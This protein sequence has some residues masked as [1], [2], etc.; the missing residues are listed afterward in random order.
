MKDEL[1]CVICGSA[2]TPEANYCSN[3]GFALRNRLAS[4]SEALLP[5]TTAYAKQNRR[6]QALSSSLFVIG[7]IGGIAVSFAQMWPC[8]DKSSSKEKNKEQGSGCCGG[9]DDPCKLANDNTEAMC[10][11]QR[12]NPKKPWEKG[13]EEGIC[14][15]C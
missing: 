3:C 11:S 13:Y 10:T 2:I 1:A 9:C 12:P 8:Y 7:I 15:D 5:Q 4:S 6:R 14:T